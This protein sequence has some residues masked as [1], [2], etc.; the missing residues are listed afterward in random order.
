[1]LCMPVF[2]FGEGLAPDSSMVD[3]T[4]TVHYDKLTKWYN[5]V[6]DRW[7]SENEVSFTYPQH[8]LTPWFFFSGI[9]VNPV[10]GGLLLGRLT[11][12][13]S[14]CTILKA[15]NAT[16]LP[17]ALAAAWV[18]VCSRPTTTGIYS[19]KTLSLS[20]VCAMPTAWVDDATLNITYTTLVSFFIINAISAFR[21]SQ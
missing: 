18:T 11:C 2:V 20:C 17:T 5:R 6:Y 16:L 15:R 21:T 4:G 1:M 8:N 10:G 7:E 19:K 9:T 12:F 13:S 14:D 3:S